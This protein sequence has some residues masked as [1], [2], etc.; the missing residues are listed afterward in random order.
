LK[1]F[2]SDFY[3]PELPRGKNLLF[4]ILTTW[5]DMNYVGLTGIEIFDVHGK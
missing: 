2:N 5:G 4:N 1:L 3:I